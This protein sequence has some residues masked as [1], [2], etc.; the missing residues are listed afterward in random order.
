M[1]QI[2]INHTVLNINTLEFFWIKITFEAM[3]HCEE[4]ITVII[5]NFFKPS[6]HF[7]KSFHCICAML[8]A[9]FLNRSTIIS[10]ENQMVITEYN[11]TLNVLVKPIE[12]DVDRCYKM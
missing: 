7:L 3:S 11:L 5:I 9:I 4:P 10:K 6:S 2:K 8:K 12:H 1:T